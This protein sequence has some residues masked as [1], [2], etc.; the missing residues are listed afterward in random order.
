MK[1]RTKKRTAKKETFITFILDETGSMATC[2]EGTVSGFNEYIQ[3][4]KAKKLN[5][6]FTLTKFDSEKFEVVHSAVPLKEVKKLSRENYRPRA[7][8][9]LY[10]AIAKTIKEA[11]TAIGKSKA[12][13]LCVVMT[14]G[15]ENASKEYTREK[16]SQLIKQKEKDGWT[17]VYLGA[18][19]DSFQEAGALGY[20]AG[21][22]VNYKSSDRGTQSAFR[23]MSVNTVAYASRGGGQTANFFCGKKDI[24]E[25]EQ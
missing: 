12:N 21:N 6:K 15:Q 16:L 8:T 23:H 25:D 2:F 13:V 4:L 18:N 5:A 24:D 3:T 9:N 19:Q 20:A 14:D 1:K 10:D 22:T 11:E 17:F 7:M